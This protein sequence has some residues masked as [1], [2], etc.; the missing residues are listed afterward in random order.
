MRY[1]IKEFDTPETKYKKVLF[2]DLTRGDLFRW[3]GKVYF[4]TDITSDTKHN[5]DW[6]NAVDFLDGEFCSFDDEEW[7]ELYTENI[8][9]NENAFQ[10]MIE[11]KDV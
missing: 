3:Q 5:G 7:V 9:L 10:D 8:V 1:E 11:N 6:V 4:R 2:E